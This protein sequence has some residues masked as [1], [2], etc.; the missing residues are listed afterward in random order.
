MNEV[1]KKMENNEVMKEKLEFYMHE[2]V[3]VHIVTYDK[4]YLNGYVIKKVKDNIYKLQESK[5]G[6]VFLFLNEIIEINQ[7]REHETDGVREGGW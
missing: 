7:F 1:K 3:K 5:M 6:E 4:L 2:K